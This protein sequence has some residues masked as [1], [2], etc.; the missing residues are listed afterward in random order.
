MRQMVTEPERNWSTARIHY[1]S[2][3]VLDTLS[4]ETGLSRA[5]VLDFALE[6]LRRQRI[7]DAANESYARMRKD[8][9]ASKKFD[10]EVAD[11]DVTLADGFEQL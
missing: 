6:N 2:K 8:P 5:S 11:W 4:T 7:L 9:E 1:R 3:L 10:E